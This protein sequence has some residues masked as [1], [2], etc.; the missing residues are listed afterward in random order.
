LADVGK[1]QVMADI[2]AW[3]DARLATVARSGR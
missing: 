2:E 3:I 1:Q